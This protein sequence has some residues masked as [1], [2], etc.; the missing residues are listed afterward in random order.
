MIHLAYTHRRESM[1]HIV[2]NEEF[3]R[4]G[5]DLPSDPQPVPVE[6]RHGKLT[7]PSACHYVNTPR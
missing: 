6:L 2:F 7:Q 1:R 4:A 5:T 3:V